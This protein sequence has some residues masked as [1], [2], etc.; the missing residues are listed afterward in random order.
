M[1]IEI[2]D[3]ALELESKNR[4]ERP[5]PPAQRKRCFA[6]SKRRKNRIGGCWKTKTTSTRK[7]G[8]ASISLTGA[9]VFCEYQLD[10]YLAKLK[11]KPE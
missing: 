4:F 5:V 9:K 3:T 6:F 1:N 7:S 10:A 2:H 11:T 8:A